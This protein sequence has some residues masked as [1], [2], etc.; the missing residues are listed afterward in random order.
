MFALF[1]K[2]FPSASY[3]LNYFTI[4]TNKFI[5][6]NQYELAAELGNRALEMLSDNDTLYS[7]AVRVRLAQCYFEILDFSEAYS[8]ILQIRE[9]DCQL[10]LLTKLILK[11]GQT[12]AFDQLVRFPFPRMENEVKNIMK[13]LARMPV[14]VDSGPD[15]NKLL[16]CWKINHRDF[17]GAATILYE[18]I[19]ELSMQCGAG[20]GEIPAEVLEYYLTVIN[21]MACI[22]EERPWIHVDD[23][24][25]TKSTDDKQVSG[26]ETDADN[27]RSVDFTRD[28]D[29]KRKRMK[30]VFLSDVREEYRAALQKVNEILGNTVFQRKADDARSTHE[31]VMIDE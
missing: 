7:D 28:A 2:P 31:S 6:L 26:E 10:D 12:N 23:R 25:N 21:V 30:V 19:Q 14:D 8:A 20:N 9:K 29:D 16:F 15:F 17:R 5:D 1:E 27:I 3:R 22:N 4:L 11:A 24:D 13:E 18:R